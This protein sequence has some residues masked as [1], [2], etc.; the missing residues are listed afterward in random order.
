MVGKIN[1]L[2]EVMD[3]EVYNEKIQYA[4]C[5]V[6]LDLLKEPKTRNDVYSE[7]TPKHLAYLLGRNKKIRTLLFSTLH[8]LF[9]DFSIEIHS[10]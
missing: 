4:V 2:M 1:G 7:A 10:H 8:A 5:E 6:Y 9:T 3:R